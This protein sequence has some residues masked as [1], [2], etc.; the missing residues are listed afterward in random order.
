MVSLRAGKG[1]VAACAAA[2][3]TRIAVVAVTGAPGAAAWS[4]IGSGV[5]N[6]N[7]WG[8]E[9]VSHALLRWH[10]EDWGRDRRRQGVTFDVGVWLH[11]RR[12]A[13]R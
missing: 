3:L 12:E 5:V 9:R 1:S 6:S 10:D 2:V 7:H 8:G 4:D 13:L 11:C